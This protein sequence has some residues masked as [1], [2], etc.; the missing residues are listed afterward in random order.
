MSSGGGVRSRQIRSASFEHPLPTLCKAAAAQRRGQLVGPGGD[1][2][3]VRRRGTRHPE[4]VGA[5]RRRRRYGSGRATRRAQVHTTHGA[6]ARIGRRARGAI[7]AREAERTHT[8]AVV[9]QPVTRAA[10]QAA[11]R[12]AQ[13]PHVSRRA[14]AGPIGDTPP[15]T[16]AERRAA[17]TGVGGAARQVACGAREAGGAIAAP[18]VA[19]ALAARCVAIVW[20]LPV[21]ASGPCPA[22]LACTA[23]K[24]TRAMARARCRANG[25][26]ALIA[27]LHGMQSRTTVAHQPT[28]RGSVWPPTPFGGAVRYD[29]LH[30]HPS[31]RAVA[32][33]ISRASTSW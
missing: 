4:P 30:A 16:R 25:S 27:R 24:G 21:R 29:S 32:H 14:L 11:A 23:L 28:S 12:F 9:A 5:V 3:G 26:L 7:L 20:A 10:H 15:V 1:C 18:R 31:R 19:R 17:V 13:R 2:F 33:A 6:V 8:R 22:V